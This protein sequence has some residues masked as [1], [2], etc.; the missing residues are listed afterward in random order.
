MYDIRVLS[1]MPACPF[2]LGG[3]YPGTESLPMGPWVESEN[4]LPFF[5]VGEWPPRTN[6]RRFASVCI[7][8][9]PMLP[10]LGRGSVTCVGQ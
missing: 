10:R 5:L 9:C 7:S 2:L 4:Q 8:G 3:F 6:R 1:P